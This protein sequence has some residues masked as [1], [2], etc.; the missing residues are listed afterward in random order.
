MP[1]YVI[2]APATV[3]VPVAG[4]GDF[5]VRRVFCVGRNYAEHQ[6]EMGHSGEEPPFFFMKPPDA[7]VTRGADTPYPPAT[8]DLHHEIELVAAIGADGSD[9]AAADALGHVFG[10]AAGIDLT[11]RDI[12]AIAKKA[13][14]PLGD[15]QGFRPLRAHRRRSRRPPASVTPARS[16]SRSPST[17][18]S[19]SPRR[20]AR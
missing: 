11:R 3:S 12:Q 18:P 10:Y 9:I 7:L 2:P 20:P 19:G 15:G 13:G 5:P 6:K 1:T 17:A 16:P 4:G 14:P 8:T